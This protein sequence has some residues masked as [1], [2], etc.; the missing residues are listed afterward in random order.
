MTGSIIRLALLSGVLFV[1]CMAVAV[2]MPFDDSLPPDQSKMEQRK[3]GDMNVRWYGVSAYHYGRLGSVG[4]RGFRGGG[5][6]GGK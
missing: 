1:A 2:A 5:L 4:N 3:Q 6:H